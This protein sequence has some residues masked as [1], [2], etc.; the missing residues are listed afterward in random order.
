M[1]RRTAGPETGF[2]LGDQSISQYGFPER[3]DRVHE[4]LEHEHAGAAGVARAQR[5]GAGAAVRLCL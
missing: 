3:R 1:Q 5:E 2:G 4:T